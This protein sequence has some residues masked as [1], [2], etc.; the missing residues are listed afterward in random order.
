MSIKIDSEWKCPEC[1]EALDVEECSE[2][3][4]M[5]SKDHSQV[6]LRCDECGEQLTADTTQCDDGDVDINAEWVYS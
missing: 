3:K 5:L 1:S 2:V 6:E 4:A